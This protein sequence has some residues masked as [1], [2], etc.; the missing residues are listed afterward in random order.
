MEDEKKCL[1]CCEKECRD[2]CFQ[3]CCCDRDRDRDR[4]RDICDEDG[5]SIF[6]LLILLL[7]VYCL[8]CSNNRRGGLFGGLF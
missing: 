7:V 6:G 5:G 4:D 8:F 3:K 2:H 1:A